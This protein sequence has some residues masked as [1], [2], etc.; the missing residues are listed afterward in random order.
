MIGRTARRIRESDVRHYVA[1][2]VTTNEVSAR[3]LQLAEHEDNAFFRVHFIG[4]SYDTFCPM[5]PALVTT[6]EFEWGRPM[7]LRT[8]VNGAVR[9]S[10]DTSD[11]VFG[12]EALVAYCTRAMTLFPGDIICTGS[13]AGVAFFMKPQAFLQPGDV[14]RCEVDGVGVI[15]NRVRAE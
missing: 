15:E 1:G 4:K 14:V 13:P 11:L 3:D 6:D 2:F 8:L 5:G 7:G 9:Q 10:S 12:F